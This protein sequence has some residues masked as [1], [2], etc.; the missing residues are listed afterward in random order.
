[1]NKILITAKE[2]LG[3][4]SLDEM[5]SEKWINLY[6]LGVIINKLR[7]FLG[8]P[9]VI[10]S[11]YRPLTYNLKIGGAKD[12]SHITCQAVDIK[13]S[14]GSL[15]KYLQSNPS[16]LEEFGLWMEDPNYTKTW[17]HLQIRPAISR[18]FKP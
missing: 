2:I 14:D 8:R 16:I 12:S 7:D 11:G 15:G 9:F 6:N 13:D 4:H 1:M 5:S 3:E 10:T 18:I 17:V